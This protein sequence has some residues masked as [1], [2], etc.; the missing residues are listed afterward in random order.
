VGDT[1]ATGAAP[2]PLNARATLGLVA[3]DAM[4]NVPARAPDAFGVNPTTTVHEPLAAKVVVAVHVPPVWLKSAEFV[5]PMVKPDRVT[6]LL[7]LVLLTVTVCAVPAVLTACEANVNEAGATATVPDKPV[8]FGLPMKAAM[9]ATSALVNLPTNSFIPPTL[10]LIALLMTV[11]AL[12]P[13]FTLLIFLLGSALWQLLH[14]LPLVPNLPKYKAL[15]LTG[16]AA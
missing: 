11:G 1:P 5:P 10:L 16:S 4:V 6:V 12:A 13:F 9:S 15:P 8:N 3:L 14:V 2:V 7:V